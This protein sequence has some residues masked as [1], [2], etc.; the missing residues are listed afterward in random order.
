[1]TGQIV[2]GWGYVTAAW[3]ISLTLFFAYAAYT[4]WQ[5]RNAA[6]EQK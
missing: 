6:K 4:E 5:A 1:M 3:G 2:G